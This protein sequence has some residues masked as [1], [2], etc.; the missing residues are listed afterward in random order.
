MR[1][2]LVYISG[3]MRGMPD[4]NRP[5]FAAAEAMLTGLGLRVINPHA[6]SAA[7][8]QEHS[9]RQLPA[10]TPAQY[11]HADLC[12]AL[13]EGCSAIALLPGWEASTGAR[14]EVAVA[15]SLGWVFLS[16]QDGFPV[17][18]PA[19]VII[20]GGYDQPPGAPELLDDVLEEVRAWQRETF[21]HAT[22]A[23]VAA[24]LL[25]EAIELAQA[26]DD[27]EEVADVASLLAGMMGGPQL[28]AAVRAKLAINRARTWGTPDAQGVVRHVAEV[29]S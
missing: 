17:P 20:T 28:V 23:S 14:C 15:M 2:P 26:P 19:R 18:R 4:L 25:E 6:V 7:L 12:L 16:V 11:L 21:P 22:R 9:A 3:P 24:H 5:A 8:E 27:D 29:A 1:A 13:H 10:P